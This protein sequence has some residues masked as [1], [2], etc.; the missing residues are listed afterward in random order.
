MGGGW[1]WGCGWVWVGGVGGG[2]VV[3]VGVWDVGG[4]GSVVGEW[5]RDV[6]SGRVV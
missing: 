2:R 4:C 3:G 6:V 1:V 5:V